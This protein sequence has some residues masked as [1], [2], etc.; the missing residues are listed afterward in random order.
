MQETYGDCL[1]MEE[2]DRYYFIVNPVSGS[3]RAK[4]EFALVRDLL[5]EKKVCYDVAYTEYHRHATQLARQAVQDGYR[6]IVSV[7][8]DGTVNEIAAALANTDAVLCVL[9]FGTGNDLSKVVGFPQDPEG[10]VETLI[11]GRIRKMDAGM[12]N[13]RFFVNV[14]GFGFDVDV[15]EAAVKHREKHPKGMLPYLMGIMD[16][17]KHLRTIHMSITHDGEEIK[18]NGIILSVG[19]G[20]YIGGGMR[21]VPMGDPFDGLLDCVYVDK[22]SVMRFLMLLPKFVKG[23]HIGLPVVHHFRTKEFTVSCPE[24]CTLDFDGELDSSTPVAF[25]VLPG[26]LNVLVPA[27][28]DR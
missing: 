5:D 28:E 6:Y 23:A 13:E 26:A 19:N 14:S 16:A 10:A 24:H 7:G 22:I 8:G 21:A 11:N 3:G 2:K 25:K 27:T 1:F 9:P 12:A 17:L 20:Q 15:L 4:A 18:C